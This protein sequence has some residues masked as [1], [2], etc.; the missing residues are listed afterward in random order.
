LTR[1]QII[2]ISR[3]GVGRTGSFSVSPSILKGFVSL[4]IL[5]LAALPFLERGLFALQNR[6]FELEMERDGLKAEI[7]TLSHVRH[8]LASLEEKEGILRSHFGMEKYESLDQ[9]VGLGG[10]SRLHLSKKGS[11]SQGKEEHEGQ[12][13]VVLAAT[14]PYRDLAVK[15]ETLT[16]NYEVLSRL[17][18]RQGETW[19]GTPSIAPVMMER[20]RVSSGFGLRTNPFTNRVEF[21]AGVDLIGPRGTKIIAPGS[22]TVISK[23]YDQWLG[24]YLVCRHT[25]RV[26]T[27]YGHL[28]RISVSEGKKVERGDVLGFMGN[29]GL[30]TSP[31]LHYAVIVGERAVNPMQFI[32]DMKE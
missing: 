9:V 11:V 26:K 3:N 32:L 10:E 25:G 20:P 23:G 21:H 29:T 2:W 17:K 1:T 15:A 22:G 4:M 12:T 28:D 19:E 14:N 8:A 13:A 27:I 7:L 5:C 31:H 24:N 18:V 30:S 16:S 6:V